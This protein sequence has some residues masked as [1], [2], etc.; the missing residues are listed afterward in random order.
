MKKLYFLSVLCLSIITIPLYSLTKEELEAMR[1]DFEN[2]KQRERDNF[3]QFVKER[4]RDFAA[5][6]EQEMKNTELRPKTQWF[7]SQPFSARQ[8]YQ[9]H[10]P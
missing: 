8:T 1:Q 4:D 5:Y 10:C 9:C 3:K 7:C 6:I 2:Y